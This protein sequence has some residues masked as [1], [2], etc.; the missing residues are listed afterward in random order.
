[1]RW[2]QVYTCIMRNPRIKLRLCCLLISNVLR[3]GRK[4]PRN[5]AALNYN[6]PLRHVQFV[7]CV[8]VRYT[9]I[10]QQVDGLCLCRRRREYSRRNSYAYSITTWSILNEIKI[11][12]CALRDKAKTVQLAVFRLALAPTHAHTHTKRNSNNGLR[13]QSGRTASTTPTR[14]KM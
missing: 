8:C 7:L 5:V 3:A 6:M 14:H 13:R 11:G 10:I 1:M 9:C 2:V 4:E 12:E